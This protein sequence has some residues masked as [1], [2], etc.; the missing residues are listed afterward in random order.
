[1]YNI[2]EEKRRDGYDVF[3]ILCNIT[4]INTYLQCILIV[5]VCILINIKP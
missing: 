2:I 5:I 1:M 4:C 3:I